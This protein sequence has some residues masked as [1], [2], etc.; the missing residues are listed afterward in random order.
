M[1]THGLRPLLNWAVCRFPFVRILYAFWVLDPY[2]THDLQEFPPTVGC[3][4]TLKNK[5]L[6]IRF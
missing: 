4:F 6:F 2:Q 5:I 3:L 1:F